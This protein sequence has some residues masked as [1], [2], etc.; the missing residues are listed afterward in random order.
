[1]AKQEEIKMREEQFLKILDENPDG[2]DKNEICRQ[3]GKKIRTIEGVR[4]NLIQKGY[5]IETIRKTDLWRRNKAEETKVL[6]LED[7]SYRQANAAMYLYFIKTSDELYTEETIFQKMRKFDKSL[8]ETEDEEKKDKDEN[9]RKQINND[10]KREMYHSQSSKHKKIIDLLLKEGQIVLVKH[11][12]DEYIEI[13]PNAS[14]CMPVMSSS[15]DEPFQNEAYMLLD[16]LKDYSGKLDDNLLS[17]KSKLELLLDGEIRENLKNYEVR[18]KKV[19]TAKIAEEIYRTFEKIDYKK[20]A[21]CIKYGNKKEKIINYKFKIGMIYYSKVQDTIYIIGEKINNGKIFNLRLDGIESVEE[22][23]DK[24]DI[25]M[26]DKYKTIFEEMF[27]ASYEY[28]EQAVEVKFYKHGSIEDK[29]RQLSITR[30]H[31]TIIDEDDKQFTYT[32]KIIGI[33][34]FAAYLRQFGNS[35]EVIKP[36]VLRDEMAKSPE[37]VLRRYK[38]EGVI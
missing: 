33:S 34:E 35:C 21:V 36:Q 7:S 25:Y 20:K 28:D 24:N 6:K 37:R 8:D 17:V 5:K 2:I 11:D 26:S 3:L 18:G 14:V 22:L 29:I 19:D 31:S 32:D 16:Y 10:N 30:I 9:K 13:P 38:E 1:M 12:N 4:N 27:G 23:E 15:Y